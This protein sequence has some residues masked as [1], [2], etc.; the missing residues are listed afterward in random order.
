MQNVLKSRRE[1]DIQIP[2]Y[3]RIIDASVH[4]ATVLVVDEYGQGWGWGSNSYSML[5]NN[6]GVT[7]ASLPEMVYGS[8]SFV[9]IAFG[10]QFALARK[11]DGSVWAWGRN[12]DG[13]L[14][15]GTTVGKSTPVSVLGSGNTWS[16][17]DI[18]VRPDS[19]NAFAQRE[20]NTWMAW[21]NN[22]YSSLGI[23]S[24]SGNITTPTQ[25]PGGSFKKI[26]AGINHT[27][28]IDY[29]NQ[30]WCWGQ[31]TAGK[32]GDIPTGNYSTPIQFSFFNGMTVIDIETSANS[33]ALKTMAGD[34]YVCGENAKY[35][36]DPSG[37]TITTPVINPSWNGFSHLCLGYRTGCA[38]DESGQWHA[39][40]DNINYL[41]DRRIS[42]GAEFSEPIAVSYGNIRGVEE[43]LLYQA[44]AIAKT[45][46]GAIRVWGSGTSG[47]LGNG[48][49]ELKQTP[50]D[51]PRQTTPYRYAQ[52][53]RF[54]IDGLCM[55]T[56]FIYAQS[57]DMDNSYMWGNNSSG[58]IG[59]NDL[60]SKSEPQELPASIGSAICGY[61]NAFGINLNSGMLYGWGDNSN[62]KILGGLPA[63]VSTPQEMAPN[64]YLQ[65]EKVHCGQDFNIALNKG[66][67]LYGWGESTSATLGLG[68]SSSNNYSSP[69]QVSYDRSF[70]FTQLA[71]TDNT[72]ASIEGST[73]Y[74]YT[75][76]YNSVNGELG[77]NDTTVDHLV[78]T[79]IAREESF[80]MLI[81]GD[82][83]FYIAH[84]ST[85]GS[86]FAWGDNVYGQL[87][88]NST[89]DR[90]S[91]VSVVGGYT[92]SKMDAA[93][94]KV[95][96]IKSDDGQVYAWG[97]GSNYTTGA[98][99]TADTSSPTLVNFTPAA[100]IIDVA[101]TSF[102][103]MAIDSDNQL[104][105]W[106]NVAY[107]GINST[108]TYT[109]PTQVNNGITSPVAIFGGENRF[110]C[111]DY[112][113]TL[114]AWGGNSQGSL[115]VGSADAV[116]STATI[117][118]QNCAAIDMGFDTDRTVL[119]CSDGSPYAAGSNTNGALGN[120]SDDT[121]QISFV[122][123]GGVS[124]PIVSSGPTHSGFLQGDTL[125]LWGG[126]TYGQLSTGDNVSRT[127][128]EMR[129]LPRPMEVSRIAMA[130]RAGFALDTDGQAWAWGQNLNYVLGDNSSPTAF[131]AS[132]AV[133]VAG[134]HTFTDIY[135]GYYFIVALDENGGAW[136]WGDGGQGQLGQ[137]STTDYSSPVSVLGNHSFT[138][139]A[140]GYDFA[141]A[142]DGS[143]GS[144]W[145]WGENAA[146]HLGI[147][148]TTDSRTPT[149][150]S[151]AGS[152]IHVACGHDH[153]V[154]IRSD[155]SLW[156]WG[157]NNLGQ[158]G[159]NTTTNESSPISLQDTWQYAA[160]SD[161]G[162][163]AIKSD[164]TGWSWGENYAG[165]LGINAS[166]NQSTPTSIAGGYTWSTFSSDGINE[167]Y[168]LGITTS[169]D[170]MAW[171]YN[172]YGKL[173]TGY[174][175]NT[176]SPVSVI[177]LGSSPTQ[178]VGGTYDTLILAD[179][180]VHGCGR[181]LYG[182]AQ[183]LSDAT[184][185][186]AP[187]E[188]FNWR[189]G[190]GGVIVSS[191]GFTLIYAPDGVLGSGR[192]D[193]G[194]LGNNTTTSYNSLVKISDTPYM[195]IDS[196]SSHV[197]ALDSV[198]HAYTW[199]DN[200][201]GQLGDN[202]TTG[203]SSAV[204]VVG[205]HMLSMISAGTDHCLALDDEGNVW[206]WGRNNQG[207]LGDTTTSDKSAPVQ[208]SLPA[209]ACDVKLIHAGDQI[210]SALTCD[211]TLY[212]WG[213]NDGSGVFLSDGSEPAVISSPYVV[214]RG[215][216][217]SK[218]NLD[219]PK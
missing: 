121:S 38:V 60:V 174:T 89:S 180:T 157:Q 200:T 30:A 124:K 74:V 1:N 156:V 90:S 162:T 167:A 112:A 114:W 207:Q 158:L 166:G 87:G 173:G 62:S 54:Q 93:N 184:N 95:M 117:V 146:G 33:S 43:V 80:N 119:V 11:S 76:G 21:G 140:C 20:D 56:N 83:G 163:F 205:N 55:G 22:S 188:T 133:K 123:V 49:T 168:M 159:N 197:V 165:S 26:A 79:K 96:A 171:G 172:V 211:G 8:H 218:W 135:A 130:G 153:A 122:L 181:N 176:S 203:R 196:M 35:L 68:T 82:S 58:Q 70:S 131:T 105:G 91:P 195:Q 191:D 148:S 3:N 179:N 23:N 193:L 201:Y 187:I 66:G 208:V 169:G 199:G 212:A 85:N 61:N 186:D 182:T 73:G 138:M 107:M 7:A 151:V 215:R 6:S 48:G 69:V 113:D 161:Y 118:M 86:T 51:Y 115:G 170:V 120:N 16:A 9:Q 97:E 194:Q 209:G 164:G 137:N 103:Q 98:G 116:V 127:N 198:G 34:W 145:A 125:A 71:G 72:G 102:T 77:N 126:N 25:I 44:V 47:S 88:D 37:I 65:Y 219:I 39:W 18:V 29:S 175:S 111:L 139:V 152:F 132:S 204:S 12:S 78:P 206:A 189:S 53:N 13:Q 84:N 64:I 136:A 24:T 67:D 57:S 106:G 99:S 178:V 147:N 177:W 183:N 4:S 129:E 36:I 110:F 213:K 45:Y 17:K 46:G 75:W 52:P 2:F 63:S 202:T 14:G 59:S 31:S 5:G 104:W 50:Y 81:G 109:T 144:L 150:V 210:S 101:A 100:S 40:G 42:N 10:N 214:N 28:A 141:I 217:F 19:T 27:I 15:D 92:W 149:Q 192:N 128:P 185:I 216:R 143:D 94:A 160:C 108:G 154:A 142:I 155:G 190:S 41:I 32:L 134:N